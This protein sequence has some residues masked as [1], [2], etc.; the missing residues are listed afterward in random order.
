[1]PTLNRRGFLQSLSAAGLVPFLPAMPAVA[2]PV[3]HSS[4]QYVWASYYAK[5]NNACSAPQIMSALNV[6]PAVAESLMQRLIS[7]NVLS[8][9]GATGVAKLNS[10]AFDGQRHAPTR[11]TST[12][13]QRG[14]RV[15]LNA[16]MKV[17][18]R[19][20][21]SETRQMVVIS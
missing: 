7:M 18:T 21:A 6:P 13:A 19:N 14:L 9:P 1:M 5:A 12:G 15:D 16:M 3:G 17:I 2:A 20:I 4:I 10:R 11:N 8:T